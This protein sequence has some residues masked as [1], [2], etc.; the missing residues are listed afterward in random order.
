MRILIVDNYDSFTFNLFQL[1]ARVTYVEPIVVRNDQL[2]WHELR[3]REP[4]CVILS[5]GP[6]RPDVP[7]DFGICG[8]VLADE[9]LPVLGVCLGHQG[10]AHAF[11]GR[12][13]HAPT[14]MHGRLST[15]DH[16]DS[17]LFDRI[18]QN[19]DVVRYHSLV[20]GEPL[21]PELEAIGWTADG[22]LMAL[23]HRERPIWGVQFH[24][25]SI[26]TTYGEQLI[27]NFVEM[28][29]EHLARIGHW[30]AS[31][32]RISVIP[33]AKPESEEVA[34]YALTVRELPEFPSLEQTF[35]ALFGDEPLAFWL[36]SSLVGEGR[37]R[38]SFMG[39]P[40]GPCGQLVEYSASTGNLTVTRGGRSTTVEKNVFEHLDAELRSHKIPIR[41]D[42]PFDFTCGFV[43][44][45]GYELKGD[46]G[47]DVT[48]S[49][50]A[51]ARLVLAD[52]MLAFDH[53]ERKTYLLVLTEQ[54]DA[55]RAE[56]EAWLSAM[57]KRL[58]NL[59]PLAPLAIHRAG[60]PP[61]FRW[62][63]DR[64]CYLKD[65]YE[66]LRR[67]RE[68][69]TYEVCLTNRIVSKT[70]VDPFTFY[71]HLRGSNP[72]PQS[73][74]LRFGAQAVA[75]SS[76]ERFLKVD[77]R[78]MVETKPIKGTVRRGASPADDA[79]LAEE[80]RTGEKGRSENL[81]IVDL[82][83]NDLGMVCEVGSVK[84]PSLMHIE[85]YATVHQ[86]VTTIQGRL[87]RGLSA[88][89]CARACFPGGSMTGAPKVRTMR[90]LDELEG[91]PRGVY[92][93]A[94]GF[95]SL[96]G[97]ADLNIV[98]RTAVFR[99]GQASIGVGGAIV[100]LSDADDEFDEM[101]LKA[102]ALV[103]ALIVTASGAEKADEHLAE[104]ERALRR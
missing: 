91:Q 36:D 49:E 39:G 40:L 47:G 31:M 43:G 58:Q 20:V 60:A 96:N 66:S 52:R 56:G 61:T 25:E 85:S 28:S 23:R 55:A 3:D 94:I 93:G 12:V 38:F 67:I 79:R 16:D 76:P 44:Y 22:L 18:P 62:S 50:D 33:K 98:I 82:L 69:E 65:A 13:L 99:G 5:P 83:R 37:A 48:P 27:A 81:M 100:A 2:G 41:E 84:V 30:S 71:R 45:L 24:P 90:I 70:D 11:G 87:R 95:F 86:L 14:P 8:D 97:T 80:L 59:A 9:E 92:S 32:R 19:F 103:R 42:L 26:C 75:C 1:V 34:P 6:G 88:V 7:A 17:Q 101:L 68:G 21:P 10:I 74:F 29:R 57:T 4:D 51:D 78:G 63:R 102:K 54:N 53:E 64:G 72:A 15:V 46:T 35:S 73:A 89:D 77:R 104:V